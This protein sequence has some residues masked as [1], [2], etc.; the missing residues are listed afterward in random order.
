MTATLLQVKTALCIAKPAGEVFEAIVNPDRMKQYF[1]SK[2]SGHMEEGRTVEWAFPEMDLTFPVHVKKT[3]P[4]KTVSF[5]WNN[6]N[7]KEMLV[8]ITLSPVDEGHTLVVITEG[9]EEWTEQGLQWLKSN[10]EG[11][12]NFLACLKA[13]LEYG[14]NLRKGAFDPSQMPA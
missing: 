14:I 3:E 2:S 4:G 11:W 10:T 7:G 8:A 13:W 6:L 12:A 5:T 1:I 9:D